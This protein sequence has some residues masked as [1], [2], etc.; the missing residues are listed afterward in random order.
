MSW[1]STVRFINFKL[2]KLIM[3]KVQKTKKKKSPWLAAL[4][5]FILPG[6]GY[7]YIGKRLLFGLFIALSFLFVIADF[8]IYDIVYPELTY[9]SILSS[10]LTLI[11]FAYDGYKTA[12][13]VNKE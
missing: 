13:E 12:E 6:L 2:N 8:L 10:L 11:A 4:L 5:N 9:I 1:P 3:K 7:L